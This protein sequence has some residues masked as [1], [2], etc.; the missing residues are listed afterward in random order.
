MFI[1]TQIAIRNNPNLYRYLRENSHWYKYLNRS[2]YFLKE[3]EAE[4][5]S[6][7]KLTPVDKIEKFSNRLDMITSIIDV[8]T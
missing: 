2:P 3:I 8:F 6:R 5:K 4:M 7:Y 1:E